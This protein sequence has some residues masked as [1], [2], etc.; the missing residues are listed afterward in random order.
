[1]IPQGKGIYV[2]YIKTLLKIYGS[3]DAIAQEAVK[4]GF[5]HVELK[6]TNGAG[7][8]NLRPVKNGAGIIWKDDLVGP[9]VEAMHKKGIKVYGWG[10]VYP[11][12][13][14]VTARAIAKRVTSFDLDG[15]IVNAEHEFKGHS[16]VA[17]RLAG[18]IRQL[19]PDAILGLSSYRYPDM[20]PSFPFAEFMH[21]FDFHNQQVYWAGRSNPAKQLNDSIDQLKPLSDKPF[22]PIG[23]AYKEH[24]FEPQPKELL[25]FAQETINLNLPGYS[26][27]EWWR[28]HQIGL[29]DTIK[30]LPSQDSAPIE[31]PVP[32][33]EEEPVIIINEELERAKEYARKIIEL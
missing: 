29:L 22:V 9:F 11:N 3:F 5:K 8:Y 21:Q 10:Y 32:P 28:A 26:F 2:W 16:K 27:W 17:G 20:H 19:L 15:F 30:D 13:V 12:L 14:D 33:K 18:K 31:I 25:E 24:G 1:M 7:R 4:L 6:V 23:F